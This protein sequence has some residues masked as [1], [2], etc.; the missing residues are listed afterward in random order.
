ML[1]RRARLAALCS[2]HGIGIL[3]SFGS[4][5]REALDLLDDDSADMSGGLSDLD[6]GV[7]PSPS[8][9]LPV[10]E[11]VELAIAI[12][13]IFDVGRVDLVVLPEVDPFL[14]AAIVRGEE[15]FVA[16]QYQA[17]EFMLYVLRRAGDLA[18][19]ERE[20]LALALGQEL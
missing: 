16:D 2:E 9:R 8:R 20:R 15:L 18:P 4:R 5:A 13:D 10:R 19:F 3:Y 7:L 17:D 1:T 12:E 14:S 6:I 11:K